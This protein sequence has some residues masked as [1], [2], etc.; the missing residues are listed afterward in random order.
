MATASERI[1]DV[2]RELTEFINDRREGYER[3]AKESKNP[4][5]QAYYRDLANQSQDW[6]SDLNQITQ[7]Y[8]GRAE[9]DTT[10][11]GKFY[12]GWMDVKAAL[13]GNDEKAIIDNN[14]YGEEWA[15][16]AYNDALDNNE[17]PMDIRQL[18]ERQ[19]QSSQQTYNRLQQMKAAL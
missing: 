3:A 8:G 6:A 9:T 19:R 7:Q 14:L 16:K 5:F 18:V 4:D 10:V 13:T 15:L 17:L 2:L 1:T 11:K 12:R